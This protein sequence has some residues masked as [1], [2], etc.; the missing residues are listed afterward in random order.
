MPRTMRARTRSSSRWW[1]G[2]I[3]TPTAC[4]DRKARSTSHR[5]WAGRTA[6]A[7]PSCL[8][9]T[10]ARGG[11]AEDDGGLQPHALIRLRFAATRANRPGLIRE[12]TRRRPDVRE[13]IF[14]ADRQFGKRLAPESP[15]EVPALYESPSAVNVPLA[16][17]CPLRIHSKTTAIIAPMTGPT[18]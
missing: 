13:A 8:F 9:G 3:F 5:P 16:V 18:M 1:I 12:A 6:P 15:G 2:R 10:L 11:S 14:P 7:V 17:A 4:S